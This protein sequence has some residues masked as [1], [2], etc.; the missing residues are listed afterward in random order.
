MLNHLAELGGDAFGHGGED[1][2]GVV[3]L[4]LE[5]GVLG[6]VPEFGVDPLGP[7]THLV[8]N[9]VHSLET[10]TKLFIVLLHLSQVSLHGH[11][12]S[13]FGGHETSTGVTLSRVS[14]VDL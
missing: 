6:E 9:D 13:I 1:L 3:W 11:N 12:I 5:D 2:N 10:V 8:V 14:S 4:L 7:V